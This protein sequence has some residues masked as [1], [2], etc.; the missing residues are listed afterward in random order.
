MRNTSDHPRTPPGTPG[1]QAIARAGSVLRALEVAPHGLALGELS[2]AVDLPKSTVHRLVAALTEEDL[3]A[4]AAD[5]RIRLGAGLARL[6]AATQG[7]LADTVRPALQ[8]LRSGLDETAD[9]AVLDGASVR[10]IDQLPAP[11]RLRAVSA[12]GS[13]FPLHCTANGKALLAARTD[14]QVR[15][16]LPER[17]DRFTPA[18]ITRRVDLL[19]QLGRIRRDEVAFDREE[20][21]EGITAV[22][23]VVRD[24]TGPVAAISVPAPTQ[25][26]A[27]HERRYAGAVRA[28]AL[29]AS[30]LLGADA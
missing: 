2:A 1:V 15:A 20:H 12:I 25:R 10:F 5:G 27:G 6:G 30:A 3:V 26:I 4:T 7:A 17:L 24:A 21:T 8:A 16:L 18:T 29:Q 19:A 9:L 28:A 22:S 11:H 14:D 23:A 13:T